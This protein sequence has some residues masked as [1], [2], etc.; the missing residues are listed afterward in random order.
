MVARTEQ[1]AAQLADAMNGQIAMLLA[2]VDVALQELRRTWQGDAAAF[3]RI[4]REVVATLPEG[5][6]S[7]VTVIDAQGMSVYNSL[8]NTE[9]V[10]VADRGHFK[11][12]LAGVD[13]LHVGEAVRSRLAD[14][15]WTVI[16]NRPI[17]DQG[18]FAGTMNISVNA[19]FLAARLAALALSDQDVVALVHP[20]GRMIARSRDQD[21]AAGR[22]LPLDRPFLGQPELERGVFRVA[23]P[24]FR[25][26]AG[27]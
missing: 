26:R 1:R 14:Q 25:R 10:S 11:V 24:G 21:L 17:L 27:V 15:R 8:G 22:Q 6:A 13:R 3:D 18:R 12:H 2:A 20:S 9:S 23:G 16:V 19:D 7:H 5:S 4:A